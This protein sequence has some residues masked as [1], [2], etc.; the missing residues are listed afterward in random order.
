MSASAGRDQ[1]W[2]DRGLRVTTEIRPRAPR[3]L[4][5]TRLRIR[6]DAGMKISNKMIVIVTMMDAT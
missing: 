4:K 5:N 3:M 6:R 2:R 1:R